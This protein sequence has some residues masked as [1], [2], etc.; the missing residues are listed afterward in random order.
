MQVIF[1]LLAIV[2]VT[3]KLVLPSSPPRGFNSFDNYGNI[4]ETLALSTASVMKTQLIGSG[5]EYFVLDGG[6]SSSD[7]HLPNGTKIRVQH[8]VR[9]KK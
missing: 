5:Y 4:N 8:L 6:W 1:L 9:S 3:G 7:Q 2:A